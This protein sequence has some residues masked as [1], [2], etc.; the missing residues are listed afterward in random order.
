MVLL[1]C[2]RGHMV[3]STVSREG[4]AVYNPARL[5]NHE[6]FPQQTLRGRSHGI[7]ERTPGFGQQPF[8]L[9]PSHEDQKENPMIKI[10]RFLAICT[11]SAALASSIAW[12]QTYT[13]VNYPGA[14]AT[15][16]VGGPNPQGT[17]VGIFNITAGGANHGFA[18]T[19]K[20]VFTPFDPPGSTN[21]SPNLPHCSAGNLL[22]AATM[23]R[24]VSCT[25]SF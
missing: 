3:A 20:G 2:P 16:I 17:S 11:I 24:L 12:A 23:T 18:V 19:A 4:E 22:W 25:V 14:A 8:R 7:P 13:A 9:A 10:I 1:G 6:E 21:T 15:E 5:T